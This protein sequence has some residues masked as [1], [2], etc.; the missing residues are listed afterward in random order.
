MFAA[1]QLVMSYHPVSLKAA[2]AL[3][4]NCLT[5]VVCDVGAPGARS[6]QELDA[7]MAV[8]VAHQK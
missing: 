5:F 3:E 7:V 2:G 4:S 6:I 8:L 1:C